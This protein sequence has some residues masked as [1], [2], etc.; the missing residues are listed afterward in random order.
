MTSINY[1]NV[2]SANYDAIAIFFIYDRFLKFSS[3]STF[4]LTKT[5]SRIRNLQH[6]F[7]SVAL[8]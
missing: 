2:M 6:S 5:E 3:M 8:S 1:D 4:Y 7:H